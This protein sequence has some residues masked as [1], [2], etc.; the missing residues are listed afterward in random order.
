MFQHLKQQKILRAGEQINGSERNR[1]F[2]K[3][4]EIKLNQEV[5]KTGV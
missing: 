2:K 5:Q 3:S 4:L 1:R